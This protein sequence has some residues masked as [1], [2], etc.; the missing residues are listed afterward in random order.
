MGLFTE[1][2]SREESFPE[3]GSFSG[4]LARDMRDFGRTVNSTVSVSG[5][6]ITQLITLR[7]W[8]KLKK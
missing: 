6:V 5:V 8:R 3:R 7:R 4:A 1:E 2:S